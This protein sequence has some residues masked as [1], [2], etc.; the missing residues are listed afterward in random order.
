MGG[1]VSPPNKAPRAFGTAPASA[2]RDGQ[3]AIPAIELVR[4]AKVNCA[5]QLKSAIRSLCIARR[6]KSSSVGVST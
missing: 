2:R 6:G 4:S 5:F 1:L 3:T